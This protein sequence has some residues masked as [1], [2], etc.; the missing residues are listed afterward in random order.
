MVEIRTKAALVLSIAV[1][2]LLAMPIPNAKADFPSRKMPIVFV[3]PEY[4]SAAAG[5]LFNVSVKIFNLTDSLYRTDEPWEPG[6]ELPPPGTRL[7]YSLGNMYGF[8]VRFSWNP[9]V[10]EYVSHVIMVPVENYPDG[11]LHGPLFVVQGELNSTA[12][13]YFVSQNSWLYPVAAFNCPNR[14]ATM[15]VFT[16]KIRREEPC[17]LRLEYVELVPDPSLVVKLGLEPRIP[18]L[19]LNGAFT[20]ENTTRVTSV[21]VGAPVGTLLYTPVL[22]GENACVRFIMRNRGRTTDS[23]NL[24]LY[25][26]GT[27]LELWINESL[28]SG[29][30][31]AYN[32]TFS[33]AVMGLGLHTVTVNAS[34]LHERTHIADS[35]TVSFILIRAP[36][37][38]VG[39]STPDVYENETVVL[40]AIE[41]LPHDP[42]IEIQNYTWLL[43]A[44]GTI[45]PSYKYEGESVTH[46]FAKNGTWKIVLLVED[47][48][49]ISYDPSRNATASY[50]QEV[51][52]DVQGGEK[53]AGVSTFPLE[54]AL[55]VA[56]LALFAVLF[57]AVYFSSKR[58]G[59]L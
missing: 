21:E 55:L 15:L 33:T 54:Q 3:D 43:Y 50:M 19:A 2:S 7:G 31:K 29:E 26:G 25:E 45:D 9:L 11:V 40:N 5:T 38:S 41:G 46:T 23:Y 58:R 37:L 32:S 56:V 39:R 44:P 10:L 4:S 16:F 14:N 52:L 47:N 20:P 22:L 12:G 51:S 6:S 17:F 24:T 57:F 42:N 35:F 28:A 18:L 30:N 34:L 49:S 1:L 48:W 59:R 13:T 53:P 27:L 36:S 8:T